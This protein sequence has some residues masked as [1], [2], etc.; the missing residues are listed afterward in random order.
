MNDTKAC[1]ATGFSR[2]KAL[3]NETVFSE[4]TPIRISGDSLFN[5]VALISSEQDEMQCNDLD[6]TSGKCEDSIEPDPMVNLVSLILTGLRLLL[7]KTIIFNVLMTFR[8]WIS[9]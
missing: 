8:V 9:Q 6:A 4:T 5:Q 7:L 3:D 1:L 2:H